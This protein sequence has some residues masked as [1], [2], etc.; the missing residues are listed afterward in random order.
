MNIF[1]KIGIN[2]IN[3]EPCANGHEQ[4]IMNLMSGQPIMFSHVEHDEI[5]NTL[6]TDSTYLG[7]NS[8][9]KVIKTGLMATLVQFCDWEIVN[10]GNDPYMQNENWDY[11]AAK[12]EFEDGEDA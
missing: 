3:S 6:N 7:G 12:A 11:E 10:I 8:D 2:F 4:W 9:Y 5:I 1:K